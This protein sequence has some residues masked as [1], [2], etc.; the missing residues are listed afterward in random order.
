MYLCVLITRC[1]YWCV[2][3]FVNKYFKVIGKTENSNQFN[4]NWNRNITRF[5]AYPKI[6]LIQLLMLI[7]LKITKQNETKYID[8]TLII[9]IFSLI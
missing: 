8:T 6:I 3:V 5:R 4:R 1:V 2:C 7:E 9:N